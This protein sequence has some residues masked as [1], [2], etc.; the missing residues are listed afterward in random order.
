[1]NNKQD[2]RNYLKQDF[3]ISAEVIDFTEAVEKDIKAT[4]EELEEM[5]EFHQYRVIKAMQRA[6]LGDRHFAVATGYGYDDVGREIVEKIYADVFGAED[7]LVRPHISS[8]THAISLAL[9]GVL[10]PGDHLLAIT[11]SPYD[12]I[13]SV[14]GLEDKYRGQG[15]IK[16]YGVSY[17][18]IELLADGRFD[19]DAILKAITPHTRMIYLQRST[20]YSWR[21]A[22]TLAAMKEIIAAIRAVKPDVIV[23]VDNCYGEFLDRVEPVAVGVD[24]MA[25]SLIK[26]PGGG[27]APTGGYVAGRSDLVHLAA[28]R[29][30]APGVARETGATLGINRTLLQGLFLAP[31]V[32]SQAIKSA[33]LLAACYQKL[34]FDVCPE[35]TDYRSDII[36]SVR[37][38][39]GEAVKAFCRAIQ[40]AAPVDSNLTPEPWD[41]PG[42]AD[43][44]IMAAGA[45]IQ[46]SSIELSADAPMREPYIVYFQGGLTHYHGKLGILLSLQ[47]LYDKNIIL[48]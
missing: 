9:Y 39:T 13:R 20:G 10:R 44:I 23:F 6:G 31:T 15:T 42:Y 47:R 18:Q 38:N 12:T 1:L 33:V 7:A 26:N 36:Q 16:E 4:L 17:D 48:I 3:E 22:V 27:L 45:F 30:S 21:K 43:P 46:G 40:E 41:M 29:L 14:I 28:C 24:L 25:G 35:V 8:G 32:V 5:A 37:L 2:I 19:Q 11:G 34:G